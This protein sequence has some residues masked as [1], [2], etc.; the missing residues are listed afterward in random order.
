MDYSY[1]KELIEKNYDISV[2]SVEK[3]KNVYKIESIDN[4]KFCL[5]VISYSYPHFYFIISAIEHLK[6]RNYKNR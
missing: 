2:K 3:I 1:V 6:N 4:S 5:K